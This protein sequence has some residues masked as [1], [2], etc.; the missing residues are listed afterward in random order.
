MT[1]I[2]DLNKSIFAI[3]FAI[4]CFE[5]IIIQALSANML[6]FLIVNSLAII[7]VAKKV[8]MKKLNTIVVSQK[9]LSA[10]TGSDMIVI[11]NK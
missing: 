6:P 9:Q 3:V 4:A 1:P 2:R 10:T 8:S 5:A 7:A 11:V